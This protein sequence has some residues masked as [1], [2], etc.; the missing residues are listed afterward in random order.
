M[1]IVGGEYAASLEHSKRVCGMCRALCSLSVSST[2]SSGLGAGNACK[3]LAAESAVWRESPLHASTAS[4][5]LGPGAALHQGAPLYA[6]VSLWH[7]HAACCVLQEVIVVEDENGQIVR[8]T[9]KDN[10]VLTQYKNMR[11]T[12]VYLSNLDHDDTERQMLERLRAQMAGQWTWNG[13]N[14]LCWAIGSISGSMAVRTCGFGGYPVGSSWRFV[15][16]GAFNGSMSTGAGTVPHPLPSC[17]AIG[18][19]KACCDGHL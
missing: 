18:S 14:T 1:S 15:T 13:L 4:E 19:S 3:E 6:L 8:E 5:A 9:M 16:L 7:A 10:D 12:L 17:S 11:E 2:A